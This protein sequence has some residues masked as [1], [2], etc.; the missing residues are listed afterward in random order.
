MKYLKKIC[1]ELQVIA[2]STRAQ[3]LEKFFK[4][5]VGEY[6]EGDVF[7]GITVPCLRAVAKRYF[8]TISFEEISLLLADEVHEYRLLALLILILKY[9]DT[10]VISEQK[11]IYDFYFE[12]IERINNWDL[13]DISAPNLVGDYLFNRTK[14]RLYTLVKDKIL[15]NRRIAIVATWYFI[16][17]NCF[18]FTLNLAELLLKDK[19][20][21]LH[22]AV[23]WML[24]EVGKRDFGLLDE[25]LSKN[26]RAMPRTMLRYAIEKFP[27]SLRKS[28]LDDL[29]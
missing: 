24:R 16:R 4:T 15:W 11:I 9:R 26:Y 3:W 14:A 10:R 21:L 1:G 20:D 17:H 23:G 6:G 29:K 18:S 2:D 19:E 13:V 22:K 28:Y 25:F 27:F 7:L 5:G 8:Q 12:H